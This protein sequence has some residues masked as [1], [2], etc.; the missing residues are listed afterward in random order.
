MV[1][2]FAM[3]AR[4]EYFR[5]SMLRLVADSFVQGFKHISSGLA[6]KAGD[7]SQNGGEFLFEAAAAGDGE[8]KMVTWCHRMTN[9]RDHTD[10]PELMRVLDSEGKTLHKAE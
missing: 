9:T 3:G 7:S 6:T 10:I 5:K 8:G 2:S 1:M 4:P